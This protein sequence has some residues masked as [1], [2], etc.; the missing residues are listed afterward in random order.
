MAMPR[1]PAS[2]IPAESWQAIRYRQLRYPLEQANSHTQYT[3]K[4]PYRVLMVT[5]IKWLI[6]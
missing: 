6:A 4:M 3:L 1:F 2:R 5:G